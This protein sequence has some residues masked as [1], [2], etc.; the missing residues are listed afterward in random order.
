MPSARL[1]Y[2]CPSRNVPR[3]ELCKSA[4]SGERTSVSTATRRTASEISSV[5]KSV[6]AVVP[7]ESEFVL[8]L[9]F[10]GLHFA[11]PTA[12][13][14]AEPV[15]GCLSGSGDRDRATVAMIAHTVVKTAPPL[16]FT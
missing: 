16:M 1:S 13:A 10:K 2:I 9:H 14:A 3:L 15:D 8:P 11:P 7:T 12:V 6:P 4:L 5:R